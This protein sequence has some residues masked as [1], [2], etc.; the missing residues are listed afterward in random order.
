MSCDLFSLA[1]PGV[2]GL[3]AYRPGKSVEELQRELGL[4]NIIKLASN[5][6]PLG[7]SPKGLAA[8]EHSLIK[9][10]RYP[11]ATGFELRIP[12]EIPE[13]RMPTEAELELIRKVID[14]DDL[15]K[16][17]FAPR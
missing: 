1:T 6:N 9:L 3:Q 10:H 17:E 4:D 7:S 12:D 11:D 14:P 15:R 8:I 5:E 13:T 2:S 16:A